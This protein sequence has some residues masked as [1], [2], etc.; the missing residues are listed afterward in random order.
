MGS[1]Q[2]DVRCDTRMMGFK[3]SHGADAPMITRRKAWKT[4]LRSWM[5][6]IVA[7]LL[8]K[9]QEGLINFGT[10]EMLAVV[11]RVSVA[12]TVPKEAS[13]RGSAANLKRSSQNILGNH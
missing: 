6:Q 3:P 12:V 10:D 4:I 13:H 1:F 2:V 7:L 9:L 8:R 11:V 5:C